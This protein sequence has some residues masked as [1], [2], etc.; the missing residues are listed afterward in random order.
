MRKK[1]KSRKRSVSRLENQDTMK[2]K[3]LLGTFLVLL[4]VAVLRHFNVF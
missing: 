2:I 4:A 3:L 1:P